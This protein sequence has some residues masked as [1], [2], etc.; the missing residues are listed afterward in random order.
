M[1]HGGNDD[2]HLFGK[3]Q[4]VSFVFKQDGT[5]LPGGAAGTVLMDQVGKK[6]FGLAAGK[7]HRLSLMEYLEIAETLH[8]Q[9]VPR[10]MDRAAQPL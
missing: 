7:F 2:L 10:L 4:A 6:F 9:P 5:Q 8:P 3:R 1:R